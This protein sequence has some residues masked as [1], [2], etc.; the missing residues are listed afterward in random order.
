VLVFLT[1]NAIMMAKASETKKRQSQIANRNKR[2]KRE[3]PTD[4]FWWDGRTALEIKP[5]SKISNLF[6]LKPKCG[7]KIRLNISHE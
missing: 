7:R 6:T 1:V 3:N 2:G 5:P 4:K